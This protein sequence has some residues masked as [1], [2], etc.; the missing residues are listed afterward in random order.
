MARGSLLPQDSGLQEELAIIRRPETAKPRSI[1]ESSPRVPTA[2]EGD[3][4]LLEKIPT[5][6]GKA[7]RTLETEYGIDSAEAFCA[8]A[9]HN[10]EGMAAGLHADLAEVD[11]LP[12]IVEDYLPADWTKRRC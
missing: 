3:R 10:P 4:K 1:D 5:V 9:V 6:P 8:N 2:K 12:K 7:R 11:R